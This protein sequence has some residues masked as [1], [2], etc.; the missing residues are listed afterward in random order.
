MWRHTIVILK[1]LQGHS[2]AEFKCPFH[3][4]VFPERAEPTL[5]RRIAHAYNCNEKVSVVRVK[6]PLMVGWLGP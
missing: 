2:E 6:G 3:T 1:D 5:R 4:E